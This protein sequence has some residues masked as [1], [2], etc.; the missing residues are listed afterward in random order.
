MGC[1][2][3][4]IRGGPGSQSAIDLG[5]Q[6]AGE[7]GE[8]LHF[9]FV[10]NLDF[11][12]LTEKSRTH[13]L[14]NEMRGMGE[15][16]LLTAQAKAEDAGVKAGGSVRQG[17]VVEEI[18]A[19]AKEVDASYVILGRPRSEELENV[20]TSDRLQA[21]VQ[22]LEEETGAKVVLTEQGGEE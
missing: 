2:L 14:S 9:L 12:N 15:F 16:I 11:L 7:T 17:D 1:I 8:S 20:F 13:V 18:T 5:I 10:V 19:L 21:F 4:P 6:L 3:C 22:R